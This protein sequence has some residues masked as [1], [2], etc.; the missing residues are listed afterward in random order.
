MIFGW[1]P[2]VFL[3]DNSASALTFYEFCQLSALTF[4]EFCPLSALTFFEFCPLFALIFF[5]IGLSY[6]FGTIKIT[7]CKTR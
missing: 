5:I 3:S 1:S 7:T 2:Q 6:A 4:F